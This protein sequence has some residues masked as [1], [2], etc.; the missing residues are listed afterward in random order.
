M[1]DKVRLNLQVSQE[2]NQMLEEIAASTSST[3]TDVIR[4]AFALIKITHTAKK[5]GHHLGLVDD[6]RKLDTKIVGLRLLPL[7]PVTL[8]MVAPA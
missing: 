2:L 7:V 6:A 3:R 5:D 8:P 4:Q 1:T